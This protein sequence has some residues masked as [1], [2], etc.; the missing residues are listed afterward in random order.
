MSVYRVN[1]F[2]W[3]IL[4]HSY[5]FLNSVR[6]RAFRGHMNESTTIEKIG[7]ASD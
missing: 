2:A 7:Y 5:C 6:F 1:D 4:L 3:L